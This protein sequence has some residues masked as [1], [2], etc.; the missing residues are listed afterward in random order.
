MKNAYLPAYPINEGVVSRDGE[1]LTKREY[2]AAMAMQAWIQ[3][4]GTKG[5]YGY[6]DK[7]CAKAAVSSADALLKELEE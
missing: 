2:F 3:H 1:G 6:S 4:H 5:G 7:E